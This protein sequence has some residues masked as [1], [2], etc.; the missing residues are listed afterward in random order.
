MRLRKTVYNIIVSFLFEIASVLSGIII[1][2]LI[3]RKY[4]SDINGL[5]QSIANAVGYIA[6]LQLGAGSV[7]KAILYRPLANKD[8]HEVSVILKTSNLFF[9]KIGLI[10]IAYLLVL[11]AAYPLFISRQYEFLFSFSLVV[12]IGIGTLGQYFFGLTYQMILEADQ[13]S[14]VYSYVQIAA[15]LLNTALAVLV[16]R[17]DL[18]IQLYKAATTALFLL[19]PLILKAYV[20]KR[21]HFD[22]SVTPDDALMKQRWDGF[23]HGLAYYIHSK[24]DVFVLTLFSTMSMISVYSVYAIITAGLNSV[25]SRIDSAVRA[26]FGNIIA[27]ADEDSLRKNFN[28]YCTAVHMT[29][30]T[31]FSTAV[32]TAQSFVAIYTRGITDAEYLQPW[33]SAIIISAELVYCLRAPY[34]SVIFAANRFKDTKVSGFVEAGLN[35][36]VSC[37]LVRSL[38]LVGVAVGTLI[39][40]AYRTVYFICY[41]KRDILRFSCLSQIRRY[42]V[43]AVGYFS[44]IV[45]CSAVPV[46]AEG[47]LSWAVYAFAVFS[48]SLIVNLLINLFLEH[49]DLLFLLRK[50]RVLK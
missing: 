10:G 47:Y 26:V 29:C 25:L 14:Y 6:V 35:I 45:L 33:F 43:T 17:S 16:T 4:G 41:L 49:K 23:A 21:Y 38:G 28:A 20:E 39:A 18:S 8:A 40:M 9:R 22:K 44:A 31:V 15:I 32:V 11:S 1:P 2:V 24:T 46:H 48:A 12:I 30:A 36:A 13:R 3:I 5:T 7:I 27:S 19:R 42:A 50:L 34:N 37:A